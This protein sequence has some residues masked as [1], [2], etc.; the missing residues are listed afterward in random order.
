MK[1]IGLTKLEKVNCLQLLTFGSWCYFVFHRALWPLNYWVNFLTTS[2]T[3]VESCKQFIQI[4]NEK[5]EHRGL[6]INNS[7]LFGLNNSRR[8]GPKISQQL[9]TTMTVT[10]TVTLTVTTW[11]EPIPEM[12][13]ILEKENVLNQRTTI[14]RWRWWRINRAQRTIKIQMVIFWAKI[15]ILQAK[16]L[17]LCDGKCSMYDW[18]LLH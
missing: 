9:R 11:I 1:L 10:V 15:Q 4:S 8:G 2:L 14:N 7:M 17:I 3:L 18:H 16:L 13:N 12:S 6:P 5:G